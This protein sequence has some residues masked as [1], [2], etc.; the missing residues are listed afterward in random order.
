MNSAYTILR[1]KANSDS[2]QTTH[3]QEGKLSVTVESMVLSTNSVVRLTDRPDMTIAIYLGCTATTNYSRGSQTTPTS[4]PC[5][6][7]L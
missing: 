1:V 4:S 6:Q 2:D 7:S 5:T 3:I